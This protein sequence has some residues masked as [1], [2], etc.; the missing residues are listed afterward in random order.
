MWVLPYDS[1]S[2]NGLDI[3]NEILSVIILY[4]VIIFTD[5]VPDPEVR[6]FFGK[7]LITVTLS[8]MS[9]H[10]LKMLGDNFVHIKT[11][12]RKKKL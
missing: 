12:L 3:M 10:I 1:A 7:I 4:H 6:Y 5:W 8:V 2:A 11:Y 9:I